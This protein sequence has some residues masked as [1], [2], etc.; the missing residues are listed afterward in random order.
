MGRDIQRAS[1]AGARAEGAAEVDTTPK[2]SAEEMVTSGGSSGAAVTKPL[3]PSSSNEDFMDMERNDSIDGKRRRVGSAS[4]AQA[5]TEVADGSKRP[6]RPIRTTE[7]APIRG[8]ADEGE[9]E[10]T[11]RR[12]LHLLQFGDQ[13]LTERPAHI[14]QELVPTQL[15][16]ERP[17]QKRTASKWGGETVRA[18]R[19]A[20]SGGVSGAHDYFPDG[21]SI[22][23]LGV[24][25]RY[26]RI[27]RATLPCVSPKPRNAALPQRCRRPLPAPNTC[28]AVSSAGC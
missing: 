14:L 19:W 26:G 16:A 17:K 20:N 2:R 10:V 28:P 23:A 8:Q 27:V 18:D 7:A 11:L 4:P 15:F 22:G 5:S 1:G 9:G 13:E 3:P 12:C 25:K 24:R 21:Q 6:S